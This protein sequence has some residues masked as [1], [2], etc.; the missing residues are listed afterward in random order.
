MQCVELLQ[1]AVD[2]NIAFYANHGGRGGRGGYGGRGG[3]GNGADNGCWMCGEPGHIKANCPN[4]RNDG[5]AVAL[6]AYVTNV[7]Y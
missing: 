6:S 5:K 4:C 1:E 2:T 3:R 7:A